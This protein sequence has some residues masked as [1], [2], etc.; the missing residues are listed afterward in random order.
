MRTST[1]KGKGKAAPSDAGVGDVTEDPSHVN[2]EGKGSN[3]APTSGP[4]D[5]KG[6]SVKDSDAQQWA[7]MAEKEAAENRCVV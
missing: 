6:N 3:M 5:P 4:D 7:N 2:R 1:R